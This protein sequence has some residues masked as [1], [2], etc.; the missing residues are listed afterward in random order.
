MKEI[1]YRIHAKSMG[2]TLTSTP[3][4]KVLYESYQRKI[5]VVT[6]VKAVYENNPRVKNLYSFEEFEQLNLDKNNSE[7]LN[8]FHLAG[9]R[10][11]GGTERKFM[12][13]DHR[14]NHAN[15]LGFQLFPEEMSYEFYPNK[16]QLNVKLPKIYVVLH[17]TSNWA[18]R[19]WSNENWQTLINYLSANR[20]F[21]ILIGKND[22]GTKNYGEVKTCH[23]YSN[24]YGLDLTN[25]GSLHDLWHILNGAQLFISLDSG[26]I[27][28]AATTDTHII[29]IG[30]AQDPRLSMPFRHGVQNYKFTYIKG[31]CDIFCT[32]N[33]K[34]S[35]KEWDTIHAVPPL[36]GCLENKPTF[37][38]QPTVNQVIT[39]VKKWHDKENIICDFIDFTIENLE[40][41]IKSLFDSK[42]LVHFKM[43]S[44]NHNGSKFEVM[45]RDKYYN[46]IL[47]L[48]SM[49]L[50]VGAQYFAGPGSLH[51]YMSTGLYEFEVYHNSQ[52]VYSKHIPLFDKLI[53]R[54]EGTE[55]VLPHYKNDEVS[56]VGFGEIYS[57][58]TY[59]HP[60]VFVETN[61]V[62]VDIG[63]N[64][65]AFI[66]YAF[67]KGAKQVYSV[68]PNPKSFGILKKH[69]DPFY[70]NDVYL[71]NY[72]ISENE[73]IIKLLVPSLDK[74]AGG[75]YLQSNAGN[76]S[77]Q[78]DSDFNS[79]VDVVT[80]SFENF[81]KE[82]SIEHIDFLKIDCE[83]GEYDILIEKY[84]DFFNTNVKKVAL[85]YHYG[86]EKFQDFLK[87]INFEVYY[88]AVNGRQ[89][90]M[91]L[92]NRILI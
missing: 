78:A 85:E 21:T 49:N 6:N 81:V 50:Q 35:V 23:T 7:I 20:I 30:S 36:Q 57:L 29:Q 38:C 22:D 45:I 48:H 13:T 86:T 9:I 5:N 44:Y 39:E 83:G 26:P 84:A 60:E 11:T 2:D 8:S 90:L 40:V 76:I 14:Q 91:Y 51:F 74:T 77:H 16:F 18:N 58:K 65:G 53:Y 88:T 89:G 72:G 64:I 68:E 4:L 17:I 67:L 47:C 33:L 1:Y 25:Q 41:D 54:C 82:N 63:S 42:F 55:K 12:R 15:D 92:K 28:L 62:V 27:H 46:T 70:D 71:N 73:G 87:K 19:T 3:T 75:C 59:E 31:T 10:D 79:T 80:K 32:S 52:L 37:E 43:N 56:M 69:F 61:D 34:Y 24:L 66:Y